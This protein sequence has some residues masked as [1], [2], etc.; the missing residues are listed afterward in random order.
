MIAATARFSKRAR[1]SPSAAA[2]E[3]AGHRKVEGDPSPEVSSLP[4]YVG[5]IENNLAFLLYKLGRYPDAHEHLDR[6]QMAFTRLREAGSLA[7]VDETRARV[8]VAERRHRDADRTPAGA[9]AVIRRLS[10]TPFTIRML[11][12]TGPCMSSRRG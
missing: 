8:L 11:A 7:Q 4:S 1:A 12:S 9:R 3:S 6:A 2:L 5:R 10:D